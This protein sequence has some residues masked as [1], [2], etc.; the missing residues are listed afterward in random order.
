MF[1]IPRTIEEM[2][3]RYCMYSDISNIL[4]VLKVYREI[5]FVSCIYPCM[6]MC[7]QFNYRHK[8]CFRVIPIADWSFTIDD[9]RALVWSPIDLCS[10]WPTHFIVLLNNSVISA[11]W[12]VML[13]SIIT[14]WCVTRRERV[15]NTMSFKYT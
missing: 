13:S 4:A 10:C 6:I 11:T 2:F 3:S 8:T 7:Y 1:K 12:T 14:H 9:D 15:N 5:I